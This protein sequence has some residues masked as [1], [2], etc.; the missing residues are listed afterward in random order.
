[1]FVTLRYRLIS[2]GQ[3]RVPDHTHDHSME[4]I[5]VESELMEDVTLN[6]S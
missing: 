6:L 2:L 5:R 3:T 4:V 1:V